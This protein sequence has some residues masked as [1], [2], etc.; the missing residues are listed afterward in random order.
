MK[1]GITN[2]MLA[3]IININDKFLEEKE[4]KLGKKIND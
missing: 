1:I 3:E 4:T 2:P